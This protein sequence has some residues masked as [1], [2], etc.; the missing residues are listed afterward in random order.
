MFILAITESWSQIKS[1]FSM[2]VIYLPAILITI[3]YM[4]CALFY[5]RVEL[6]PEGWSVLQG[7]SVF[8]IFSDGVM[9]VWALVVYVV[10]IRAAILYYRKTFD[11]IKKVQLRVL[12]FGAIISSLTEIVQ[13]IPWIFPEVRVP[14]M[15]VSGLTIELVMIAY[16]I[17]RYDFFAIN[18][19]TAAE[20]IFSTMSD[21]VFVLSADNRVRLVNGAGLLL[22]GQI[23][24]KV[25]GRHIDS[26][27]KLKSGRVLS[28]VLR[29]KLRRAK[30]TKDLGGDL[31]HDQGEGSIPVSI[32]ATY[33]T[34]S[35]NERRGLVLIARDITDRKTQEDRLKS[36]YR[37]LNLADQQIRAE[38]AKLKSILGS[39]GE[40]LIVADQDGN[41]AMV[42]EGA[43]K[44]LN[45]REDEV[46]GKPLYEEFVLTTEEKV[47]YPFKEKVQ[48][49]IESKKPLRIS[50]ADM[51]FVSRKGGRRVPLSLSTTPIQLGTAVIG[52]VTTFENVT[53]ELEVDLA[54]TEFVSLAA[55]QLVTPL[56]AIRWNLELAGANRRQHGKHEADSPVTS[57]YE[58]T[59]Q[60]LDLVKQF[61]NVSRLELGK[62]S[63]VPEPVDL[64]KVV[65]IQVETQLPTSIAKKQKLHI[66]AS[67]NLPV[68]PLDPVLTRM[69]VQNLISNAIKY[70]PNG[71]K[72]TIELRKVRGAVEFVV[73]DTGIGIPRSQQRQLFN[74]LFRAENALASGSEGNGLGLYLVKS[75]TNLMK[76]D[77]SFVSEENKGTTFTV[78]IPLKGMERKVGTRS[79]A[80]VRN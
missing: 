5:F 48:Q 54:K 12:M 73:S 16:A 77:I 40:G 62:L 28:R 74:K 23:R 19:S 7:G 80:E 18:A 4:I 15:I 44:L 26:L 11:P 67:K 39:V 71:G 20:S 46:L 25:L 78:T 76:G 66:K 75:I 27:I 37:T 61:L 55:H 13:T 63:I 52:S 59:A 43:Q 41:I 14:P 31:L 69:V 8:T 42:N 21:A 65:E 72:V 49:A 35:R 1:K 22:I 2:Y 56:S 30:E 36:S 29:A 45:W 50:L 6:T 70:T 10:L 60:M 57:A 53:R 32:S 34:S 58:Q 3:L 9:S 33:L 24:D 79:L 51:V 64:V 38:V 47:A 68:I 17:V